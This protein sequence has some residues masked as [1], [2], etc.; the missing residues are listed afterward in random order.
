MARIA[1]RRAPWCH[2]A[3]WLAAWLAAAACGYTLGNA[4]PKPV[5][6]GQRWQVP[7]VLN[8]S[9]E[10]FLEGRLT[11]ALIQALAERGVRIAPK[12]E[13][14]LKVVV[15]DFDTDPISLVDIDKVSEYRLRIRADVRLEDGAGRLLWKRA[16]LVFF[17]EFEAFDESQR[18][19]DS[20]QDAI[21]RAVDR[22]ANDLASQL[23][24]GVRPPPRPYPY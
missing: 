8:D 7:V 9:R 5:P 16:D 21:D 13:R 3:W 4:G 11:N 6:E 12:A 20:R 14:R 18:Q 23:L 17:D 19:E 1:P 24:A 22:F 15:K 2:P 10:P